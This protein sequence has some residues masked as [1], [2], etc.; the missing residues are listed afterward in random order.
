MGLFGS[1]FGKAEKPIDDP[2]RL[3]EE[4]FSAAGAGDSRRLE[5][6][7]KANQP[8]ILEHFPIWRK[9]PDAIRSDQSAIQGY[10][11]ALLAIAQTFAERLGRPELMAALTGT[12]ESNSL[13]RWQDTLRQSR[14]HINALRY[15]EAR[16]LLTDALIDS[17]TMSG[18]GVDR[19]LPITHGY[20]AECYFNAGAAEQ[21][22]P[23]LE[24][25]LA[26]CEKVS[27][28]EG[29]AAYLGSLF[30]A[31]RYLGRSAE[32]AGFADR[33]AAFLDTQKNARDSA[34]WRTRARI[35]RT[36]EPLN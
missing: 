23:H 31:H 3:R 14:E 9:V 19:Y 10:V 27:D 15:P 33:M 7:A 8:A 35:V 20:L 25:A 1:L 29:I 4:L 16:A 13:L 21:A 5:R 36:G 24:Q 30:E 2:E 26:L 6:I 34:R 28:F 12:P 11:H 32:A 18:T 22:L 17:R